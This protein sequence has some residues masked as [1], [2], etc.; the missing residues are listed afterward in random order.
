MEFSWYRGRRP[1]RGR[2]GARAV[3]RPGAATDTPWPRAQ[4]GRRP[5]KSPRV[6]HAPW[7][8]ARVSQWR[9]GRFSAE[10]RE[11]VFALRPARARRPPA[12][13]ARRTRI[14][15]RHQRKRQQQLV[16][17]Q[18]A[19]I[20]RASERQHVV[21][22]FGVERGRRGLVGTKQK[23]R[24]TSDTAI[25]CRQRWHSRFSRSAR[26]GAA[27]PAAARRALAGA[28][29]G[30]ATETRSDSAG[31]PRRACSRPSAELPASGHWPASSPASLAKGSTSSREGS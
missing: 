1:G 23:L 3:P 5:M 13:S 27:T 10:G 25:G 4:P 7:P 20:Q 2:T 29:P 21:S 19:Q 31:A 8:A 18:L 11:R 24:D 12:A 6:Y 30:P 16:L 28:R 14:V 26:S 9:S 22:A 15:P 17:H